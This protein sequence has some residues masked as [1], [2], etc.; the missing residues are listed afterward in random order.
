MAVWITLVM[1]IVSSSEILAIMY[2]I[3]QYTIPEDSHLQFVS[4]ICQLMM[5]KNADQYMH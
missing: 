3:T 5:S 4:V 2:Q 1:E